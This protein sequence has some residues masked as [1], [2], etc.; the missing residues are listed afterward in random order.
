MTIRVRG[1]FP[2]KN[3]LMTHNEG[4]LPKKNAKKQ[5]SYSKKNAQTTK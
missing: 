5:Y 4:Y 3:H 2:G 1:Y